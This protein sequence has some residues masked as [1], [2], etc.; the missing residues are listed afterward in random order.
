MEI[1]GGAEAVAHSFQNPDEARVVSRVWNV[2][3]MSE[4]A[5]HV[6]DIQELEI[7]TF[8]DLY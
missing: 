3:F 2:K 8:H 7:V 1:N 4:R 5:A 6:F